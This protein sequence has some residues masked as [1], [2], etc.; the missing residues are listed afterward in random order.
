MEEKIDNSKSHMERKYL[1]TK[2]KVMKSDLK[3]VEVAD[4][5]VSIDKH[6]DT[7]RYNKQAA[8]KSKHRDQLF[9]GF[10]NNSFLRR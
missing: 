7:S 5:G 2:L 4:S 3:S 9:G 10:K 8:A 1:E 6:S